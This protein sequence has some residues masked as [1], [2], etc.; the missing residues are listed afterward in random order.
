MALSADTPR[1]YTNS[2]QQESAQPWQASVTAYVGSAMSRDSDGEI[3]PLAAS[4]AFAGFCTKQVTASSTA[5]AGNIPVITTGEVKLTVTGLDDNDDIGDIVYATDDG[6][7]TLTS[8]GGVGIG[9]VSQIVSLTAGTCYVKFHADTD[10]DQ[11]LA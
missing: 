5:G 2:P 4:E 10:R 7:F 9:R 3:G 11:V 6:T 8:S 1:S